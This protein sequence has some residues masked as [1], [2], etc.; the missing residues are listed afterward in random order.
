MRFFDHVGVPTEDKQHNEM[1]VPATKVWVTDPAQHPH[2]IEFLRFE[3]DS[4]V[5]GAVRNQPH[6]AFRVDNLDEAIKGEEVV[7]GPFD[8]TE[9][10]R[11][12]FILKDGAVYEFME[13][14]EAGHW[15]RGGAGT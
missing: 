13:S 12:V 8:A 15:F 3:P 1:Y 2:K 10:L 5:K 6:M 4:P 7:L 11:V 14:S 9:T